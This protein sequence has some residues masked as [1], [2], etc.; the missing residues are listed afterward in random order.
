MAWMIAKHFFDPL[1]VAKMEF[2]GV[3]NYKEVL[4][5]YMDLDVLP[6]CLVDEGR[7]QVAAGM[8]PRLEGGSL[9]PREDNSLSES[10]VPPQVPQSPLIQMTTGEGSLIGVTP[11]NQRKTFLGGKSL[12][13]GRF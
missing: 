10:K 6:S 11:G 7:G 9:P 4:E 1:N 2:C 8:P 12:C 13:V 3:N 5:R